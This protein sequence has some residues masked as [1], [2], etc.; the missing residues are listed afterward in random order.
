MSM[1]LKNIVLALLIGLATVFASI[2]LLTF[3]KY[4]NTPLI[5]SMIFKIVSVLLLLF[6]GI[7]FFNEK[8]GVSQ[9]FGLVLVIIG[10]ALIFQ[11]NYNLQKIQE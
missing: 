8:Y 10:S 4:Y 1:D 11:K 3:D 7:V 6:T 2:V 5:N 9:L